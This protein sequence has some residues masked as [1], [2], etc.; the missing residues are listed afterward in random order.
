V[1]SDRWDSTRPAAPVAVE[2]LRRGPAPDDPARCRRAPL[3]NRFP[4]AE[5]YATPRHTLAYG[6]TWTR[7]GITC[8]MRTTGLT[9]RN[10]DGHGLHLQKGRSYRF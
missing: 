4:L 5:G 3:H 2:T 10:R 6:S 1:G 9:C 8:T 7:A